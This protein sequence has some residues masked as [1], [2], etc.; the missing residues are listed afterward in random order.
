M[1]VHEVAFGQFRRFVGATGY[2]TQV[3]GPAPKFGGQGF[4]RKSRLMSVPKNSPY[5]WRTTGFEQT[6][7]SPVVNV[8]WP[9]AVA[10][11]RWLSDKDGEF[12]RLP[13]ESEWEYA[14]RAGTE[15]AY[16]WG[17]SP[18]RLSGKENVADRSFKMVIHEHYGIIVKYGTIDLCL[19]PR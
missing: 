9:D 11:C 12:F 2:T 4:D 19:R 3:E 14:C 7:R 18:R 5:S 10:F 13:T 8:T 17:S 1:A 15:T 16:S 6:D